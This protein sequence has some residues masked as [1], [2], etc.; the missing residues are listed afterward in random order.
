MQL[1]DIDGFEVLRRLCT[2]PT[3]AHC[4]KIALS[5]NGMSEAIGRARAAGFD[6]FWAKPIDFK[7]FLADLDA[8]AGTAPAA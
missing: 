2:L 7:R 6:D 1:P 3:L 4:A 8:L 5:A